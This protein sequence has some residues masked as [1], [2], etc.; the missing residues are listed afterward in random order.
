[1]STFA[2]AMVGFFAYF[3]VYLLTG[4]SFLRERTGGTLERLMATPVTRGEVVT[5]YT[6]GFGLFATIQVAMLMTWVLSSVHVPAIGPLPDFWIGLG[7]PDR[8]E[9]DLRVPRGRPDRARGR[10]PWHLP[11]DLRPDGAPDH[12][13]HPAR[14]GPAVPPVGRAVPGHSLPEIVQPL[15]RIM[16]LSYAV[17]G[18]RQVFIASADLRTAALQFDLAVLALFALFFATIASLTIRR[19]V[20]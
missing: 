20:V 10:Q 12:P 8:G 15:V 11:V 4:V 9:P 7:D 1:M 5:G 6:L 17:D 14:P 18:L 19:D 3:F 2:P 16:P 13:V